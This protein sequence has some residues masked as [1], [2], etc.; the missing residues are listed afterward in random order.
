[1]SPVKLWGEVGARGGGRSWLLK[2]VSPSLALAGSPLCVYVC[3][4][5]VV[6]IRSLSSFL[7][8]TEASVSERALL[9]A[10]SFLSNSSFQPWFGGVM[11]LRGKSWL[12]S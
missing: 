3:V 10:S 9:S 11:R 1:M 7:M 6:Y 8:N 4:C 12:M 2:P 5:L